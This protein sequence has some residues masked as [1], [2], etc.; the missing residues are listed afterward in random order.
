MYISP[1]EFWR[2]SNF[3]MSLV[4]PPLPL[5]VDSKETTTFL[6][7]LVFWHYL[8]TKGNGLSDDF[9]PLSM[10]SKETIGFSHEFSPFFFIAIS[11]PQKNSGFPREFSPSSFCH[12]LWTSKKLQ[13]FSWISF[14]LLWQYIWNET[15]TCLPVLRHTQTDSPLGL[16]PDLDRVENNLLMKFLIM[17]NGLLLCLSFSVT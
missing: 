4:H 16:E 8:W 15:A 5:S 17:S 2:N 14:I 10:D 6:A 1:D 9:M 13:L 12:Y 3:L 7:S 11:G